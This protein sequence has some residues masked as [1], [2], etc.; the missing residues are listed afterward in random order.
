[1]AQSLDLPPRAAKWRH[2]QRVNLATASSQILKSIPNRIYSL[3]NLPSLFSKQGSEEDAADQD[4]DA[5]QNNKIDIK[6][7]GLKMLQSERE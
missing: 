6:T 1:V 7:R 5:D 2:Q 4:Q 3:G